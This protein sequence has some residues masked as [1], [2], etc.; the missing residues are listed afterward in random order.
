MLRI[1]MVFEI[2]SSCVFTIYL[3][4]YTLIN[5]INLIKMTSLIEF[6]VLSPIFIH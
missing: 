5:A 3:V 2:E 4:L 6:Q 1:H